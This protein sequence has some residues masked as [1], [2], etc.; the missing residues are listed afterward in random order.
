MAFLAAMGARLIAAS[1]SRGTIIGHDGLDPAA[2]AE[3][4]RHGGSVTDYSSGEAATR[5]AIIDVE[6][7]IW[8]PAARPDVI[9]ADNVDRLKTRLI[10]QGANIPITDEAEIILHERG[11]VNIPDFI[12]NA[13]GVICAAVEYAGG[14]ESAALETISEKVR[15]NTLAV[16]ERAASADTPP[17]AAA[18]AIAEERV[19]RAMTFRRWSI[20]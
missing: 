15:F 5:D 2:L 3:V 20:F 14:G 9:T 7:D 4:K 17:R 18:V 13:G 6:C 1:D 10:A 19:R 12:A 11:I 8:I 16:L